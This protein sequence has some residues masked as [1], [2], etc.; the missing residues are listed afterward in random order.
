M[1]EKNWSD[2]DYRACQLDNQR[3]D[4]ECPYDEELREICKNI[5]IYN[6][7]AAYEDTG[8]TP[9]EVKALS[10]EKKN[11]PLTLEE[12]R[13]M[14][15]EP[16]YL[17]FYGERGEYVILD[18]C[19]DDEDGYGGIYLT[20]RNGISSPASFAFECGGKLYRRKPEDGTK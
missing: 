8:L 5:R 17:D 13:A 3:C 7:L 11:A 1:T 12:L 20:H 16:V 10:A 6:R 14:D 2:L 18:V 15:G 19:G 4:G 9:E